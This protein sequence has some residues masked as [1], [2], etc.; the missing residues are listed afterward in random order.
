MLPGSIGGHSPPYESLLGEGLGVK[1]VTKEQQSPAPEQWAGIMGFPEQARWG[2]H[3]P[4][5][6]FRSSLIFSALHLTQ[7]YMV[8]TEALL[9]FLS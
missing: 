6:F 5:S 8:S 4:V 9:L 3:P 1:V 2:N 7:K